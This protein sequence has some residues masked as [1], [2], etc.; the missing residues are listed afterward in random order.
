VYRETAE[1]QLI[2][3]FVTLLTARRT[4]PGKS[5]QSPYDEE[6]AKL[7]DQY[8]RQSRYK[9]IWENPDIVDFYINFLDIGEAY[10]GMSCF[11]LIWAMTKMRANCGG[12]SVNRS[13]MN[14]VL[15]LTLAYLP[16]DDSFDG[17]VTV[18]FH[19]GRVVSHCGG[20]EEEAG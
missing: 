10:H 8:K 11:R 3:G 20:V 16:N 4:D 1:E 15:T 6:L 14:S 18:S 13:A 19:E 17:S 9:A 12:V 5:K 2:R 7:K